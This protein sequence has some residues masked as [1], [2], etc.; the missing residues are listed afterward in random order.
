[1]SGEYW[2][3]SVKKA[4]AARWPLTVEQRF[5]EKISPE[6]NSGCWLWTGASRFDGYGHFEVNGKA[7]AAH[8]WS[9]ERYVAPIPDGLVID[10]KCRVPCCVNPEHLRAVT[11]HFNIVMVGTSRSASNARKTHCIRGHELSGANVRWGTYRATKHRRCRACEKDR[12][13]LAKTGLAALGQEE[14]K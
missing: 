3:D 5:W 11:E 7:T 8:R 2:S 9:Y 10:H 4:I 6:P 14:F 12:Q 13:Q 1:M